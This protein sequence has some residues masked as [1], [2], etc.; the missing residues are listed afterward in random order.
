MKSLVLALSFL[1]VVFAHAD[2]QIVYSDKK[3]EIKGT[4][5]FPGNIKLSIDKVCVSSDKLTLTGII[6]AHSVKQCVEST[7]D[8]SDSTHP[9]TV[10]LKYEVSNIP[11]QILTR[12]VTISKTECLNWNYDYSDSIRPVKTCLQYGLVEETQALSYEVV[13]YDLWDYSRQEPQYSQV[14]VPTCK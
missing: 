14:N 1:A 11:E 7:I 10:C 9:K 6:P 5:V 12:P 8:R 4:V 3:V 13:S 2:T